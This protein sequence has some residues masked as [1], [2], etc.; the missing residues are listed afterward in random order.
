M[1]NWRDQIAGHIHPD[2]ALSVH[3]Y[4]GSGKK[5][6]KNLGRYDVVITTYGALA[7]EYDQVSNEAVKEKRPSK[8]LFSVHWRRVVLDEAHT[9][10]TPRTKGARA[11]CNLTADSRWSLTGTPIINNLKDLYSQIKFLGISG[12]LED[13]AVFNSKLIRPLNAGDPDALLLL[14]ALMGTVCLRRK[15]EMNFINLRLPPLSS[16]VLHVKFLPHE[17]EQ[18]DMFQY[19][20]VNQPF[21]ST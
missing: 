5:E 21:L 4:H 15:K 14:Q 8:G 12:G 9:I 13:L 6:A 7:S 18:Y 10:R 1:S 11:A 2:H 16:H 19:V 3:T 17:Q 20:L